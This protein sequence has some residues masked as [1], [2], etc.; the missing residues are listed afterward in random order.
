MPC[1]RSLR[2]TRF[3]NLYSF[4]ENSAKKF[5]DKTALMCDGKEMTFSRLKERSEKLAAAL[6]SLG[7]TKGSKAGLLLYNCAEYVEI[8]FALMKIGAVGVPLNVRL[9]RADIKQMAVHADMDV[10]FFEKSLENKAPLEHL[11]P[12]SAVL[13][14]T[15]SSGNAVSYESL[16]EGGNAE[17]GA[18]EAVGEADPSFIVYTA[19][20][21][22]APKGVV[23][24]HGSQMANTENY[25]AA[26]A[27]V[28][29][30]IE[31]APTPLFHSSTLGR[32]FTYVSIGMTFILCRRFD[33][34][35][36]LEIIEREKVTAVTQAPTLYQMMAAAGDKTRY[37]TKSVTRAV[38]GASALLPQVK[39]GLKTLFPNA[40]FYDLY[41]L[42]EASPGVSILGPEDFMGKPGCV[43]KP[44]K[45]VQIRIDGE[46]GVG[47]ILCRGPNVMKGYYKDPAATAAALAG[48]WLHTGDMG[49]IGEDGKLY[50]VGRKKEIIITGG[51]N[52]YPAEVENVMLQYPAVADAAVI[53]V[54]DDR[55]GE[56]VVA[57]VVVKDKAAFR[58]DDLGLFCRDRLAGFKCP[59]AV[60]RVKALPRNAAQKVLKNELVMLYQEIKGKPNEE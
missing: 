38:S 55:W 27:P 51:E 1:R 60:F 14:G 5:P 42:T 40:A 12:N 19:G 53:G 50:I 8:V 58:E 32:V 57:A 7:L 41:G 16:F 28:P 25:S 30:D 17:E 35:T 6:R 13:I 45:S 11:P 26:Y 46:S 15:G 4:L 3:M 31:L 59:R 43:G 2:L 49:K 33:P 37:D 10:L 52:V 56:K 20:T 54:P 23:L 44:M 24:T 36:A 48:G 9:T 21:T 34:E 22:S 29:E 18:D 39:K 47:E